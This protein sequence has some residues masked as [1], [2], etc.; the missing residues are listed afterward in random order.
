MAITMEESIAL[1]GRTLE[2]PN[3]D[4]NELVREAHLNPAKDFQFA[5]LSYADLGAAD[6]R[7]FDF[8]G[9]NLEGADLSM[10]LVLRDVTLF[11][12]L[13][14]TSFPNDFSEVNCA[15]VC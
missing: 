13:H 7:G 10:G 4:F 14:N 15:H 6:L 12:R 2:H 8:T 11:A 5:D 9:A 3:N 1:V